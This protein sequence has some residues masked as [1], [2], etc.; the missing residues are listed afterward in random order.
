MSAI[1]AEPV[2]TSRLALVPLRAEHADEMAVVL[3]ER[4]Q[5]DMDRAF[6]VLRAYARNTNT[7][8][9]EVARAIVDGTIDTASIVHAPRSGP[10]RP[11]G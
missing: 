4:G 10:T 7:R 6:K 11:T 8:L 2:L 5:F 3:A 9:A 1:E